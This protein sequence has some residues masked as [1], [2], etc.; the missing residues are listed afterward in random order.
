MIKLNTDRLPALVFTNKA[1]DT[2]YS[3]DQETT[4]VHTYNHASSVFLEELE[5]LTTEVIYFDELH[6]KFPERFI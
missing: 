6:E 5:E 2:F 3:Y 4:L 1:S